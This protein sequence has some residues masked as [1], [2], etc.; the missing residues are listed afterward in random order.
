MF[1][2]DGFPGPENP[3]I[4]AERDNYDREIRVVDDELRALFGTLESRA[5][6]HE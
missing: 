4:R 1:A 3:D 5:L 2:D 6:I